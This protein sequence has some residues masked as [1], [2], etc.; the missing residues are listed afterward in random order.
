CVLLEYYTGKTYSY[1]MVDLQTLKAKHLFS[2]Q[3]PLT[4]GNYQ[5]AIEKMLAVAVH[6]ADIAEITAKERAARLLSYIFTD[7]L[8]LHGMT[9][10]ENQLSLALSMLSALQENKL[11]L[12]E[13][14]VG[15][16]KT[17]AYILAVTVH[18]LFTESRQSAIISTSTIALQ[19]AL[20]EEYIPQISKILLE[21]HITEK[22]LSFVVRKGKSHYACDNRVK[23]YLHSLIYNNF[24]QDSEL[25]GILTALYTGAC[26]IDLDRL[27]LT[28]YVKKRICVERCHRGCEFASFCRYR[29]FNQSCMTVPYDFQIANHNLVLADI[30]SKKG[31]RKPLFPDCGAIIFDEAHKL[32]DTARQMYGMAFEDTELEQ[33]AVKLYRA[34][35]TQNTDR[36][37]IVRLCRD[38][39]RQNALL[40]HYAK[41]GARSNGENNCRALHFDFNCISTLKAL[42]LILTRLSVLFFTLDRDK[43]KLYAELVR[44]MESKLAKLTILRDYNGSIYWLE[45]TGVTCRICTLP[46]QLDFLLFDDI[47]SREIPYILTSGTLS[48]GGDFTHIKRNIGIA[49]CEPN[50]ATEISKASPFDYMANA[51]LY[52]PAAMPFPDVKNAEYMQAVVEQIKM[53]IGSTYGHTLV[54]FTSYRMMERVFDTMQEHITAYPFFMMGKGRLNVLDDFRKSGNGILFASDSAGEG[55]DL[56]GDILS[57]LIVVRLPF[58]IPDPIAEYEKTL[59]VHFHDYLNEVIV[60]GMLIKLRQWIGRGIRRETDTAVLSILDSRAHGRYRGDILAALPDM[61]VTDSID[62]VRRFILSK[63]GESYFE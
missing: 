28:E 35:G 16:G 62:E 4:D 47:W 17:H 53:L 57:S 44:Q 55:I 40:F 11:A 13:A 7:I 31:G 49:L 45:Q 6:T 29:S 12:C 21:H 25:I 58:P 41:A 27:P 5:K 39:L 38:M 60:P 63:K 32:L 3:K 48:V 2:R 18:N 37:E 54:L 33:L 43:A 9:F 61:P 34:I 22:P 1:R 59:Y 52:L 23:I 19:K 36:G 14:E 56:A 51:L 50:R 20:T 46:K 8:P 15:T 10:R 42:T 30:L 24:A 26:T